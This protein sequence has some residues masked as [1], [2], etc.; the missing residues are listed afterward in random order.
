M[1]VGAP[2]EAVVLELNKITTNQANQSVTIC[3]SCSYQQTTVLE[4]EAVVEA[5]AEVQGHE[6]AN[7]V[8]TE[9]QNEEVVK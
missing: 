1:G 8:N 3:R 9:N 5:L 4:V 6:L 7:D 2:S